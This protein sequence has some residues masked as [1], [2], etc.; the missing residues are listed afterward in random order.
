[1]ESPV[2]LCFAEEG[3][4]SSI[5]LE[6]QVFRSKVPE[7]HVQLACSMHYCAFPLNGNELCIL[8]TT[9]DPDRQPLH[10]LGHHHSITALAFGSK[11]N[12]LLICSASR[13]YV[14]VWN[15]DECMKKF[16]QGVMPEGI[17]IGTLLG[18]VLYV[19]FSPDDETVAVC[20]G[21]RIYMLN[22]KDE[23]ILAELEGHL[24]PV[25]AAEFCSWEKNRLIS[26]SEDRSFKVWD[27]CTGLLIYQSAV[28][29]AFP[30]LSLFI[31]E[32]NKQIITGCA[33][34]QLWIFS[35]SSGHQYRCV[36]HINIKKER[37][38]FYNKIR[39]S[40]QL[41]EIQNPSKAYTSN[42]LREEETVE[43]T[44][45]VLRIE[46][47]DKSINVGDEE[48]SL[49][50]VNA[51]CLWIGSSTGLFIINMANFELEAVLHYRDFSAL[52]IQFAGSCALMRKAINGKVFCLL[53]S[54]FENRIALLEINVAALL[55]SQQSELHLSGSEK[56]LSVVARCSLLP[57]SPLCLKKEKSQLVSKKGTKSQIKDQPLVFHN[58]IKSSGYMSAPQMTM[59]SPKTNA[60]QNNLELKCKRSCK[61]RNKEDYPRVKIPPNKSERQIIV[62]DKPT[63]ICCIQYSGDGELLACGL[64][65][66]TLLAF[67][68]NLTGTPTVYS[69]HDGAVNSVG[70]SHDNNWLVSSSEDRT[71]RIWSVSSAEPALCLGKE[72]FHKSIR[73]A[74]F[75]Y[76]DTFILLSC[77]AEFHML[78]CYLD[79]SK[80]EMK[81]YRNKSI[82][83]SVQKF[84]MASTVEITSLSAVNEFYSYIV[85]AAG[86]N[87]ALEVFD[88]NVG[89]SAAVI[90][91]VHSRS[92]HQIC[93]N[94]GSAFSSQQYEA[95]NLFLTTAIG[96]GIKLW[97]LRTLRC[98]RH[99]KGHSSRCHPC[100]I[101]VSPCGQFIA[102]G[103]EDKCAYIYEMHSSTYSHKLTGHTESVINVAFNPSSPQGTACALESLFRNLEVH[104]DV[105]T[106]TSVHDSD[107]LLPHICLSSL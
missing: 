97:D 88:L 31:D 103:S 2:D 79:T 22:T 96:D 8:N 65:D 89:C 38:K 50:T 70:W 72:M 61:R 14:I 63:S 43:T 76:I 1:M 81:R 28:I 4:S 20:A 75:Y 17:V 44:F 52:S 58:K 10:L 107:L 86:S 64:A 98:E 62:A 18:M 82:C 33:D 16:L 37:E 80:D 91:D 95:Y 12:P 23:A 77:G 13:D 104:M 106:E 29:T 105:R 46:L 6:K 93:Q 41:D 78:R 73:S 56:G 32:E 15:L 36:V 99:Y 30:L 35:L 67:N 24:A 87:R 53:T 55:R 92:V 5:V 25:T 45:P 69:G 85:L 27:Y 101:A 26:V 71:L 60:K 51:R 7:S 68:S 42:N 66:K 59:F 74:Q 21:N 9:D 57:T 47:C 40:E 100:G 3:C 90:A 102:C 48:H 39:K 94:K 49:P 84:P 19:R 83:K 34:G 11:D 54:M